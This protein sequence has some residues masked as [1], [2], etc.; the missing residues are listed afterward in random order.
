M[1]SASLP[2]SHV[3]APFGPGCT[4]TRTTTASRIGPTTPDGGAPY[5]EVRRRDRTRT[6]ARSELQNRRSPMHG[7]NKEAEV[8]PRQASLPGTQADSRGVFPRGGR[9]PGTGRR[10]ETRCLP[11]RAFL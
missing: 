11:G 7:A 5:Q 4:T 3:S 8:T 2:T 1:R 9:H 6:D 10:D